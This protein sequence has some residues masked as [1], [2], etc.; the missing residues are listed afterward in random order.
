MV[1]KDATERAVAMRDNSQSERWRGSW[2]FRPPGYPTPDTA[3]LGPTQR[4][5]EPH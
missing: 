5:L 4:F 1:P 3:G 2:R